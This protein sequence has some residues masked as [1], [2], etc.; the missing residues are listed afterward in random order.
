[1]RYVVLVLFAIVSTILSGS[2]FSGLNLAGIQ[3]DIVL[4]IVLALALVD[5]SGAAIIFAAVSRA[6]LCVS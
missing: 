5:K 1:M 2:V 6:S 4:L 3:V